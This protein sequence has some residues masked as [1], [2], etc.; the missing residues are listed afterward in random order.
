MTGNHPPVVDWA[1]DFDHTDPAWV[2]DPYPIW[3]EL[4]ATCPVA[5][6]DRYGGV[7]LPTRHDD[8][9]AIA[10]DTD[11]FTS[12]SVVVTEG[13]PMIPAPQGS[14]RRSPRTR[15]STTRPG[16][17]C[18]PPSPPTPSTSWSR[19]P[20]L[21][22]RLLDALEGRDVVDAAAEYAQ[23]IPVRVIA[24][25]LGFP[26]EDA[27]QFRV[28]VR[29]TLESVDAPI[30]KRTRELPAPQRLSERPDRRPRGPP[31]G[32]PD[33]LPAAGRDGR[34]AA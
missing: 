5:H 7:W 3:D 28:F 20:G 10:Y 18:C 27:D 16:A 14:P 32:R 31:P 17:C 22:P 19:S 26:A 21:L 1:T 23:H 2:G 29:N 25:M 24:Q 30:E 6:S 15:R 9:S 34:R 12:Q 33:Q 11:H 13:R 4:R 8:V